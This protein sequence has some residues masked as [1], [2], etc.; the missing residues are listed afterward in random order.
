M[1]SSV[2]TEGLITEAEDYPCSSSARRVL[3]IVSE[4]DLREVILAGIELM[5]N[6]E[7]IAARSA[8]EGLSLAATAEPHAILLNQSDDGSEVTLLETL[9]ASA[10]LCQIPVILMV[11]RVRVTDIYYYRQLGFAGII[12]KPFDCVRLAEQIAAFLDWPLT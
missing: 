9:A 5:T 8:S 3:A 11:E 1:T 7:A 10:S 12:A 2:M 4:D 6:W